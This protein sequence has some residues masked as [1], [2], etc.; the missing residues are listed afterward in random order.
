M[1]REEYFPLSSFKQFNS[2]LRLARI[3]NNCKQSKTINNHSHNLWT[4]SSHSSY[5]STLYIC[6]TNSV[7]LSPRANYTDWMT[8]TCWRN[9]VSTFVGR[10]VSRGQRGRSPAVVNLSFLDRFVHL[11]QNK[12]RTIILRSEILKQKQNNNSPVRDSNSGNPIRSL[13]SCTRCSAVWQAGKMGHKSLLF[14]CKW[15][16][17]GHITKSIQDEREVEFPLVCF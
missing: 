2:C 16:I 12:N 15:A 3:W 4:P 1:T 11:Q 6:K 14:P 13:V 5:K 7:A 10:G 9:L 17:W 8:A